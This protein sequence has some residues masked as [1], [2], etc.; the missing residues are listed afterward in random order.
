[1]NSFQSLPELLK[2]IESKQ[3]FILRE[4]RPSWDQYFMKVAY[5]LKS[6]SNC[7]KNSVGALVVKDNRIVSTGYNGTPCGTKNC[8]IGGCDAC[9]NSK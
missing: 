6:R 7:C 2:E 9:Y 1:M 3:N 8:Y 5:A 4:F